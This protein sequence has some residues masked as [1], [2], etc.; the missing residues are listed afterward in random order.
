MTK[1]PAGANTF[2]RTDVFAPIESY[3]VIG[4]GESVTCRKGCHTWPC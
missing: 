3:E 1:E 4:D 2:A